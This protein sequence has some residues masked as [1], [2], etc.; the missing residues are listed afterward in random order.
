MNNRPGSQRPFLF[1]LIML[2]LFLLIG[3]GGFAYFIYL[4]FFVP[5]PPT[6]IGWKARV[7]TLA[8]N[9]APGF[10]DAATPAGARFADPFG[11][12]MDDAGNVYVTDAGENNRI[13]KVSPEGIVSTLAGGTE[14]HTDGA[15]G[16]AAFNSPSAIALDPAGNLIVADTG[17]NRIRRVSPEGI[18]TTVAGS[19]AAGDDDGA[20]SIAQF[21]APVGVAVDAHGN[22]FVADTYNDRIRH[23]T[24]DGQVSTL[25]GG[26]TPGDAD[27]AAT[28]A[29]F[30][31]PCAI[32]VAP[33]G[34]LFIADTGNNRLRKRT[35]DG[36]LVTI[37]LNIEGAE[38]PGEIRAPMGLALTHDG[39]LYVTGAGRV[40][41][42]AP[43]GSAR[44]LA[45]GTTGFAD[46][47]TVAARFNN[48]AGIALDK[49][50]GAIIVADTANYLVRRVAPIEDESDARAAKDAKV[51]I[52]VA[53]A[54]SG[55]VESRAVEDVLPRLTGAT[56][57]VESFPWP[58]EPQRE[59]HEL[60]ATMGEVRGSYDGES[61]H[62]LH[63]GIDVPGNYGSTVRAVHD[64]K[65][66][67]PLSNWGFGNLNEG[68]RVGLMVYVHLHV[69]R[70]LEGEPLDA[71]QFVMLRDAAGKPTRVRIRRGARFRVGDALGTINRMYHV[72]LN[73]G[74]SGGEA[75][76][77]VLPLVGLSDRVAP[78]IE[79]DGIRLFDASG[80]RLE[81]RRNGRVLVRRG[82]VHIVVDAYDQVDGNAARRRLGL[83]K[84]GY[85]L[86]NSD[87]T[88]PAPGFNA[89][90]I[91]IEFNRLPAERDA[92]KIAYADS[93]GITVY[94]NAATKFL[95]IV[96][97]TVRD[98][99]VAEGV[100]KSSELT[101]G[102]Y[103]LRI[104]AADFAG[105]E[106][107]DGRDLPITIE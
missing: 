102:D 75:N 41:Q 65:V 21:N 24:P 106:A 1:K 52:D 96:T 47:E 4:R 87:G 69:G 49:S 3:L 71:P 98:G 5:P 94:G 78:T 9:G 16:A 29:R 7:T 74:P 82:D 53:R 84:L 57:G 93:S 76:P 6:V 32:V 22:I 17:N 12:A 95:Y 103:V 104:F 61:R 25:A 97:N 63:S 100:W 28:E 70:T 43:D 37:P 56:V 58:V 80:Q 107:T 10:A 67:N 39:F 60:V 90:R 105:N 42:V 54:A 77:L 50:T 83:Y 15:G 34:D 33:G 2:V 72:H 35:T 44:T 59:R 26:A 14:G 20:A 11:V 51:S 27:G 86:L 48:P 85:Q 99:R 92:V 31:T 23:I 36:R 55:D 46:G 62:H 64:E 8:G 89:P 30:D 40:V 81:A 88:A 73:F 101:P 18:V 68:V 38:E 45:G 79:R 19:G 91:Q 66:S 13:R